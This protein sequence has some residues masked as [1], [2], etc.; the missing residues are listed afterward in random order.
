MR[1]EG[2]DPAAERQEERRRQAASDYDEGLRQILA[3]PRGRRVLR[4]WLVE[5]GLFRSALSGEDQVIRN[6]GRREGALLIWT[7]CRRVDSAGLVRLL[8][9][10]LE[11]D[12]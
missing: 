7:E 8:Q 6:E 2:Q 11:Q 1:E 3:S 10:E 5:L 9:E 4:R 12:G